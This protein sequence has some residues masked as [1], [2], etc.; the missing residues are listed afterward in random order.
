MPSTNSTV[1]ITETLDPSDYTVCEDTTY[2]ALTQTEQVATEPTDYTEASVPSVTLSDSAGRTEQISTDSVSTKNTREITVIT[3]AVYLTSE[4]PTTTSIVTV[5]TS[6]TKSSEEAVSTSSTKSSEEAVST[7]STKSSEE[8]VST[9]YTKSSEEAVS[10]SETTSSEEAT[11]KKESRKKRYLKDQVHTSSEQEQSQYRIGLG[12]F[13]A[14]IFSIINFGKYN[15]Q[16]FFTS[17]Q[18]S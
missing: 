16:S 12:F 14:L 10:T 5:S 2:T 17:K 6:S 11:T 4:E 1:G 3:T 7:S 9:S 15:V 8:A 18:A 13:G